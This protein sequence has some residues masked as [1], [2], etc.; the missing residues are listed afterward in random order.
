V[1]NDAV[2][3]FQLDVYGEVI[4]TAWHYARRRGSFDDD[5]YDRL[6]DLADEICV[7]WRQPDASIWEVRDDPQHFTYS[8]MQSWVGL[9]RALSFVDEGHVA[10]GRALPWRIERDGIRA[11]VEEQCWSEERGAWTRA[12]GS[13]DLDA[14]L[15]L[16]GYVGYAEDGDERFA[17]T[18]RAIREELA[19]GALVR[20]Y[21][22]EDNLEGEEGAFLACSF[23]LADALSRVAGPDE[24]AQVFEDALA[25]ANDVGVFSEEADPST[26]EALGNTPQALVHLSLVCA[27]RAIGG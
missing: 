19:E 18:V 2:G 6:A 15:L 14:S 4:E 7:R 26:G 17:S 5:I 10:E 13:S 12:A 9:E 3:Q 16:A 8:K 21:R 27:A 22:C 24:G 25:Y 23:W 11:F 20:R 1:G